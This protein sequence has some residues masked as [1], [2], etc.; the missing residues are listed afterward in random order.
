MAAVQDLAAKEAVRK[1]AKAKRKAEKKERVRKKVEL[2]KGAA[3]RP[4]EQDLAAFKG[5]APGPPTVPAYPGRRRRR[6]RAAAAEFS[7]DASE[8]SVSA[9]VGAQS[10]ATAKASPSLNFYVASATKP[11]SS[12]SN[13][14]P[15]GVE[16]AGLV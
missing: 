11:A 7:G 5:T 2:P 9:S 3:V 12:R 4:W 10:R 8:G 6:K 13:A 15:C 14:K 1:E 16:A